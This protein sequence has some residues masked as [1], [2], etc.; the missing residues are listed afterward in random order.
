[1]PAFTITDT[2]S[3]QEEEEAPKTLYWDEAL[4]KMLPDEVNRLQSSSQT[5]CFACK[6]RH[7]SDPQ[8][9]PVMSRFFRMFYEQVANTSPEYLFKQM[10]TFYADMIYTPMLESGMDCQRFTAKQI[11]EHFLNHV[12]SPSLV[13][14]RQLKRL[15]KIEMMLLNNIAK[16]SANDEPIS[17][18]LKTV[19]M[20][21]EVQN[22]IVKKM[23]ANTKTML[24]Y[25]EATDVFSD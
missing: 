24:G 8:K 23:N 1:M 20:L 4:S 6:H 7:C 25:S 13:V 22:S 16:H 19:S 3:V 10:A 14:W 11:K 9:F 2:T 5:G 15:K 21:L 12:H 18:N 17:V